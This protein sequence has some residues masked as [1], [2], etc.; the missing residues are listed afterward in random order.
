M[1]KAVLVKG[2]HLMVEKP[3][4]RSHIQ[5]LEIL[6]LAQASQCFVMLGMCL[7]YWPA[8]VYLKQ[9]IDEQRYG[10]FK[11]LFL[12]RLSSF[13]DGVFYRD[14]QQCGGALL[15]LHIHDVDFIRHCL[16]R[17]TGAFSRGNVGL[18]GGV[19]HVYS[20]YMFDGELKDAVVTAQGGWSMAPGFP[21]NMSYTANFER[22]TLVY[23]LSADETLNVYGEGEAKAI[24]LA[25][26]MGY[27]HEIK[28]MVRAVLAG[29]TTDIE[30]LCSAVDGLAII[31]AEA[32]SIASGQ[33]QHPVY[34]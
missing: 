6:A 8:W 11:S 19:D 14:S 30:A 4:A 12:E 18:S 3:V 21:F 22:A 24:S 9:A 7:R 33:L 25:P 16:G 28:H 20:Q 5:G 27:E 23:Q 1:A 32:L 13:P 15:D 17:P 2:R 10:G 31:E 29:E 34:G 26:G